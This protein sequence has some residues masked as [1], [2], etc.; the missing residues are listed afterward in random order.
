MIYFSKYLYQ[1]LREKK[2]VDNY[3]V[4]TIENKEIQQFAISLFL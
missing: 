1:S 3:D 2:V 4:R